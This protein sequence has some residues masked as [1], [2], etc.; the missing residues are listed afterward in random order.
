MSRGAPPARAG[1]PSPGQQALLREI[2]E[3]REPFLQAWWGQRLWQGASLAT[4]AGAPLEVLEPGWLNRG[5]GP[6]FRQARVLIDGREHWGDVEVHLEGDDWWAHGHQ[7]DPAYHRVV[8]HVV[9]REGRRP[10]QLPHA[11]TPLPVLEAGRYLQPGLQH[12]MGD[13]QELLR[14]LDRLPGR[15]G[16]RAARADP[17]A[18]HRVV[19]HAAEVRARNKAERILAEPGDETDEQRLFR[20]F[21]GYLGYRPH[22]ELFAALARRYPVAELTLLLQQPPEAART[23]V[24]ARWFGAAGLLEG[25]PAEVR[26]PVAAADFAALRDHWRALG[27]APLGLAVSRARSRPLNA[28]ERRLAGLYHHLSA[29][30]AGGWLRGWLRLLRTLDDRRDAPTFRRDALAL[31]DDAFRAPPDEPWLTRVGF[32]T[33][34]RRK[35]VQLIGRERVIV[36]LAN[37][38]LPALLGFARRDGDLELEKLLYRLYIVLP[39]EGANQRTVFMERRLAPLKPLRRTLRTHQGLLQIHQDFC[40]SFHEGCSRCRLPDLIAPA[41]A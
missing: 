8:L 9:L 11:G 34:P 23:A 3:H 41:H 1:A 13:P 38:V 22:V 25:D 10:V 39:P 37:A 6:D 18:L 26:D 5:A 35:P 30:G 4:T 31:L 33:P 12:L 29:W 7:D 32:R 15:C 40:L 24:L 28:P 16:L 21:F 17:D 14:R 27:Q 19:A 2:A 20:Q 36:L